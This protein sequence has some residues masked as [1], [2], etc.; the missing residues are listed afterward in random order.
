LKATNLLA[1]SFIEALRTRMMVAQLGATMLEG[2]VGDVAIPRQTNPAAT[3]WVGETSATT[4]ASVTFDQ[5]TMSPKT[6]ST[7]VDFGWLLLHQSTPT[8]DGLIR[9]DLQNAIAR[10]IDL[11]ALHGTGASSQ[12]RGIASTSG[13]G[14][15]TGGADG[16][17]PTWANIVA[18]ETAVANS[19]ADGA[20]T[21]YLVNSRTRGKLKN[22]LKNAT[23]TDATY[24]W[25]PLP[26]P[27]GM[28]VLNGYRAGVSN[29]VSNA[30]TNGTS[31]T[32][33]SAIFFGNWAD[34]L[35]GSWSGLELLTN[36][37][38]QAANRIIEV[39]AHQA[40]DIAVR[41]PES[42]ALMAD[43]ITT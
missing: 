16:A 14:S 27:D 5:V 10:A 33:C 40:L 28:G 43:A 41:H 6:I 9:D 18:L 30:L 15:V 34:L 42:F 31:T 35:I 32:V 13:I 25:E 19:N 24:L 36:P 22:V 4:E 39:Y 21:A 12:P 2:L 17:V 3:F 23:A 38:T 7:R 20:S 29:Q 8:V 11:A 1:G 37:Y 26:G